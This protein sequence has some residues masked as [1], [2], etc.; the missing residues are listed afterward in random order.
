MA[1]TARKRGIGVGARGAHAVGPW[2]RSIRWMAGRR[3]LLPLLAGYVLAGLANFGADG[4]SDEASYLG[5]ARNLT[6]GTFANTDSAVAADYLWHGPGVPAL[7]APLTAL[8]V[9]ITIT[10]FLLG[11]LLLFGAIL[12]FHELVRPLIGD[13]GALAASYALGLY[14]PFVTVIGDVGSEA[15]ATLCFTAAVAF[16]LRALRGGRWD[17][18]WAAVALAALAL[19][20][21]EYGWVLIAAVLLSGIWWATARASRPA[22][23][24]T[25]T[26]GVAL[27]LCVPWLAYTYSLTDKPVYWGNSGGLS[28]YWMSAPNNLGD[29]HDIGDALANPRFGAARP[30]LAKVAALKPLD[31]DTRLQHDA[32][33]NIKDDPKHYISNLVNNLGRL[34]F[35][36]PYT[37]TQ[38]KAS[39]MFYAV[40]N[41]LLMTLLL[42]AAAVAIRVRTR[43]A[44]GLLPIAV[45]TALGFAVHVPVAAYPR[46]VIPLVPIA[47]WLAIAILAPR[48]RLELRRG[49][50][51]RAGA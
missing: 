6:H 25:I 21:V 1:L 48:I 7:L 27:L 15:L 37:F 46:F 18:L 43:L 35:N 24:A 14:V 41:A 33:Q 16:W 31:Q 2:Q 42:I 26:T 47:V 45:L 12:V 32:I 38:Q 9:P 40:P 50:P 23:L 44:P 36:A 22:R 28:L 39:F 10:R 34:V 13:R 30:Q 17:H 49:E 29:W 3:M 11:A 51:G 5:F 19:T 4:G 20:R 8:D